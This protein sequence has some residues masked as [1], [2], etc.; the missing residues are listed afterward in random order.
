VTEN[1]TGSELPHGFIRFLGWVVTNVV[2]VIL[3]LSMVRLL[4]S[5]WYLE[6]EYRTPGF[7]ED[8]YA[9]SM[10]ERLYWGK[11][12]VEYLVNDAGIE[13]LA[14]LRFPPGQSIPEPSCQFVD[15]CTRVYNERELRHMVAVKEVVGVAM[16]VLQISLAL[17]VI[18]AFLAWRWGWWEQYLRAVGRGG[19]LTVILLGSVIAFVLV[20][21]GV[22]FVA[23]HEVFFEPGTWTFYYSDTL[24]RLFP[25]RFWRDTF[26]WAAGIPAL[27]GAG[28]GYIL[29]RK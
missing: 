7:P 10:A 22:I 16:T 21:F 25:E 17:L 18:S 19:W 15:D 9:F 28:L 29:G 6:L 1:K 4:I 12:A 24:I 26:L 13:Y 11:I 20:A 5:P 2:P 23:F 3:V 27:I 14:D 8:R